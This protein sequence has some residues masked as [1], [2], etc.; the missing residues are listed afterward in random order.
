M[1]REILIFLIVPAMV[2][3]FHYILKFKIEDLI[4]KILQ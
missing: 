4:F 1:L 2:L 3:L